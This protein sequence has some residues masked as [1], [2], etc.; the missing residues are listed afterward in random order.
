MWTY[1]SFIPKK[2]SLHRTQGSPAGV[3]E[4]REAARMALD[5]ARLGSLP[6]PGRPEAVEALRAR[7]PGAS[8]LAPCPP[9]ARLP[10]RLGYA[11]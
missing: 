5:L 4:E 2:W 1:D 6:A 10:P 3:P 8:P 9:V 11:A 7:L